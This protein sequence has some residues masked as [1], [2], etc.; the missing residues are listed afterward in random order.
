MWRILGLLLPVL[1]PAWRFFQT[2]EPSPRVEV[3]DGK[4]WI[5]ARPLP[6]NVPLATMARRLFWSPDRN[7]ALYLTS[8]AERL[9]QDGR[10]HAERELVRRVGARFRVVEVDRVGGALVRSVR[11][12]S[13]ADR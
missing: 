9:L 13:D 5:E 11:F 12:T 6:Q 2:I 3:W 7:E 1:L 10:A 4:D 8:L